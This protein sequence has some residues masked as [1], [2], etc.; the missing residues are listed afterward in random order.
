MES[1][2]T[3]FEDLIEKLSENLFLP[4][5]LFSTPVNTEGYKE[6][7]GVT[8]KG[9]TLSKWIRNIQFLFSVL[10]GF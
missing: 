8:L 1:R 5:Y 4:N 7:L 3:I 2:V 9:R 10:V 6:V